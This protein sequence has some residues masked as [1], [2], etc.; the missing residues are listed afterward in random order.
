MK[1]DTVLHEL[2]TQLRSIC[3]RQ[4][5]EAD[6]LARAAPVARQAALEQGEWLEEYMFEADPEQG[7]GVR[8][9]HEEPGHGLT[10]L[11]VSWLPH[12]GAP[13]HDHGT[14]AVVAGVVG[15]ERN[16]FFQ[17][18][19][20]ASRPG[21]AE[22][23]RVGSDVC[24][25]GEVVVMPTGVIH[26]VTNEGGAVSLSLHIYGRHPN[27]TGRSQ[28]DPERRTQTAFVVRMAD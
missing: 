14:W 1:T 26:S 12:R 8:L 27:H 17:R 5:E 20:D 4:H 21:Y 18:I 25:V 19:D 6:I 28:F 22:L 15:A 9:L 2:V 16:D 7:F 13:P 11:A 23:R 24:S 10:V 3:A